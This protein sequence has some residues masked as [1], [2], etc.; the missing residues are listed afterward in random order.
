MRDIAPTFAWR[1]TKRSHR[2]ELQRM[3]STPARRS[4]PGDRLAG[5]IAADLGLAVVRA[6]FVAEGGA[7]ATDGEGT[8]LRRKAAC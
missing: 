2:L 6:P 4:R 1:G 7:I 8:S 3:G 5:L